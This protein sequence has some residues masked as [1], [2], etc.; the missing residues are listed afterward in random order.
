MT[1]KP[2]FYIVVWNKYLPAIR[3]LLKR[4]VTGEQMLGMNR[5]DF[6]KAG[7]IRK[8]GYKFTINFINGRP[9]AMFSG[10]DIVQALITVLDGDETIHDHLLNSDYTLSF[11]GKY[12][13]QIKN[14]SPVKPTERSVPAEEAIIN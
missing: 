7:G 11:N 6:E 12:Q 13:L 4:S 14:N 2:D 9:N 1:N 5:T 10:N 8:S 3:I